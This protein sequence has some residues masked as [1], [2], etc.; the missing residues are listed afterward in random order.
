MNCGSSVRTK[1]KANSVASSNGPC[2]QTPAGAQIV[3]RRGG[4]RTAAYRVVRT[5]GAVRVRAAHCTQSDVHAGLFSGAEHGSAADVQSSHHCSLRMSR[6]SLVWSDPGRAGRRTPESLR[7]SSAGTQ[8]TVLT[9]VGGRSTGAV[10][11][12]SRLAFPSYHDILEAR[13]NDAGRRPQMVVVEVLAVVLVA[14]SFV[15]G[16]AALWVGLLGV[17]GA[18]RLVR[19]ERCGRLGLTSPSEPLVTCARCRHDHLLHPIATLHQAHVVHP[20]WI[21]HAFDERSD[22]GEHVP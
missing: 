22:S 17:L 13:V 1:E 5:T 9:V 6:S 19:C 4:R 3:A 2:L 20:G 11:R 18:V 7:R 8:K 21:T 10:D 16:T 14:G 15:V 12:P